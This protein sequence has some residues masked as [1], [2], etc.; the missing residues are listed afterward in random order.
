MDVESLQARVQRQRLRKVAERIEGLVQRRTG[1]QIRDLH[2]EVYPGRVVISGRAPT[3]YAKQLAQHAAMDV[4][5]QNVLQIDI[6][7]A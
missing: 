2:V 4:A 7:V 5:G 3:Y 6:E 1:C